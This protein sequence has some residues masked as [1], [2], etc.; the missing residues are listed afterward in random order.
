MSCDAR[1]NMAAQLS[2]VLWEGRG[3][4][5]LRAP[6]KRP[7]S[8]NGYAAGG[9]T[10]ADQIERAVRAGIW[11]QPRALADDQGIDEDVELIDQVI[12]EQPSE[13]DTAAGHKQGRPLAAPSDHGWPRRCRPSGQSCPSTAGR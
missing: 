9:S 2:D 6:P 4:Y 1:N 8:L 10:R 12:G 5:V 11:E 3:R 7:V 13:E